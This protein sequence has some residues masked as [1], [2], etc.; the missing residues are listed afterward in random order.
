MFDD[1]K[2]VLLVGD[3]HTNTKWWKNTVVPAAI[4]SGVDAIIQVGDFGWWPEHD[5]FR[6]TVA[7][8]PIP[9][10]FFDG[11]HEHFPD[12]KK[13]VNDARDIHSITD[14]TSPV[15]LFGNLGYLPRGARFNISG[16]S[17]AVVGG[18]HSID[19]AFRKIGVSYF[20][21]ECLTAEDVKVA[22]A[23]G[24]AD[25]LLCHDAPA[26]WNI[27][28]LPPLGELPAA[29]QKEEPA[30]AQHRETLREIYEAIKPAQV[31]HGHYHSRYS[32]AVDESWGTVFVDGLNCDGFNG[33]LA[34]FE[35]AEGG[36]FSLNPVA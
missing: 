11:N 34:I 2:K 9:V 29:W 24:H 16:V 26:G 25:V 12:L 30:C 13:K 17:F 15:P 21:D 19:R 4:N 20:F 28:G 31:V 14:Q 3:S 6:T 33:S 22:S 7:R 27:P 5:A 35:V 1:M 32:K 36:S 23:G 10:W 18:A 8:G